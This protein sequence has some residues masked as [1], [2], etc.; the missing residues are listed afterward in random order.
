MALLAANAEDELG[1]VAHRDV[2]ALSVDVEVAGD[3][4]CRDH[5][6]PADAVGAEAEVA[7]RLELAELD[8][9]ARER[10]RDDRPGDVARVLARSVVVEHPCYHTGHAEGVVVVH[11]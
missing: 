8:G 7:H 3:S 11:R 4:A 9:L 2:L 10:L 5:Q 1:P 6:M